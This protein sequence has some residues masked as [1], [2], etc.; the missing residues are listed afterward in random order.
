MA[1][2]RKK[3]RRCGFEPLED[4]RMMAGDVAVRIFAG[5]LSING[6]MLDNAVSL[7]AG[8]LP[9]QVIISTM[10]AGGSPTGLNGT[11]NGTVTL[12]NFDGNLKINMKEGNDSVA[13]NNLTIKGNTKIKTGKGIDTVQ[14]SGTTANGKVKADLGGRGDTL[15][16]NSSVIKGAAKIKGKKGNDLVGINNTTFRI[17]NTQLGSGNDTLTIAGTTAGRTILNGGS[18]TNTFTNG[19]GNLL[20]NTTIKKFV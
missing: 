8:G 2:P 10:S 16:V 11:P 17:L 4:R 3:G 15:T 13:I 18:G 7:T 14:V 19:T 20:F 1:K 12:P 6:D 9:N 5:N